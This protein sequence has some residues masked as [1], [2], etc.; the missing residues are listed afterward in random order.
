VYLEHVADGRRSLVSATPEGVEGNGHSGRP[1]VDHAATRVV[2]QSTATNLPCGR[3]RRECGD[4]INLVSDIFL[5]TRATSA[6]SRVNVP[7]QGL[8]WLG[9]STA[10]MVSA[11]GRVVA[12][13]SCQPFSDADDRRTFDLF[14]TGP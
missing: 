6:V 7:T 5:W 8:P 12:F 14:I 2:F 9:V 1:V 13:F 10:P 3:S 11:D 4:D